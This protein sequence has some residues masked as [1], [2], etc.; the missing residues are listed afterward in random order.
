VTAE[1]DPPAVNAAVDTEE[2]EAILAADPLPAEMVLPAVVDAAVTDLILAVEEMMVVQR[3]SERV[4]ASSA[5][6]EVILSVTA[7]I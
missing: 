5:R 7:P 2:A 4:S 3:N 1:T 6:R